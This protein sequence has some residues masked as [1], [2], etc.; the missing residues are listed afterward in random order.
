MVVEA[1]EQSG[2]RIQANRAVAHGRPVVLTDLVLNANQWPKK[3]QDQPCMHVASSTA[4]AIS[5]V[6]AI[7]ATHPPHPG[8][9]RT[10]GV[11]AD[12]A[13]VG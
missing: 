6:E 5:I 1:G 11:S 8:A 4:E 10:N 9:C 2:A 7:T 13:N 12:F 3:L